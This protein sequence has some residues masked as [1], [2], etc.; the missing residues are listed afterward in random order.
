MI[1]NNGISQIVMFGQ[2]LNNHFRVWF[3]A[4]KKFQVAPLQVSRAFWVVISKWLASVLNRSIGNSTDY[5]LPPSPPACY[6][7]ALWRSIAHY[8]LVRCHMATRVGKIYPP[9][10][11]NMQVII[12][13]SMKTNCPF[14]CM[15]PKVSYFNSVRL[16]SICVKAYLLKRQFVNFKC[17]TVGAIIGN[18]C[19][20]I[21]SYIWYIHHVSITHIDIFHTVIWL[22]CVR[23]PSSK[24]FSSRTKLQLR[25]QIQ[26]V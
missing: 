18:C 1:K 8:T 10:N 26:W 5:S 14:S 6:R 22:E 20:S 25:L 4:S 19:H 7:E 15:W 9:K 21:P 23:W 13:F 16:I 17:H 24:T 2:L 11:S 12:A 3:K